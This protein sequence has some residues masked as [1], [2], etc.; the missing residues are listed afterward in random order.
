MSN[1]S[2]AFPSLLLE[3]A[4]ARIHAYKEACDYTVTDF[5]PVVWGCSD[6]VAHTL[7][8]HPHLLKDL[9]ES[10]DLMSAYEQGTYHERL[11]AAIKGVTT[12]EAL[13]KVLREFRRREMVR[14]IWRD[15][16]GWGSLSETVGDL[17]EMADACIK[18][19]AS[20]LYRW[21][22]EEVGKPQDYQ[23]EQQDL[24][25][26]AVGKLG[27]QELNL[28][29]DI[30]LIFA[31]P[32]SGETDHAS[33]PVSHEQFFTR[34]GQ[35]LIEVLNKVTEHGFVF[36][37]DMRLR[38]FGASGSLVMSFSAMENYY[39]E[40][41]RDWERYALVKARIVSGNPRAGRKLMRILRSFVYH[42]YLDYT[43]IQALREMHELIVKE[44]KSREL[45][46]N[47][48]LGAGGIR[49][50][51]FIGQAFQLIRGG[52]D[53]RLQN[54]R[55]LPILTLL[56][57]EEL[58]SRE[59]VTALREAYVFLRNVEHRLQA[60]ADQ[61]T[62]Q[63]PSDELGMVRLAFSMS[64]PDWTTFE[65]QLNHHR[66]N[67]TR[68]FQQLVAKPH[69]DDVSQETEQLQ[70]ELEAIW[71]GK[72]SAQDPAKTLH[73]MGFDDTD[74][75]LQIL[76]TLRESRKYSDGD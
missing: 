54:Q 23:G 69:I 60:V 51:E 39:Q 59:A 33:A 72:E 12:E 28:S 24:V 1:A 40:H 48:K 17:S 29:S 55:L 58:L 42:H 25:V 70:P 52:E 38:P 31:Y 36:R 41:G 21:L 30:D 53:R 9:A 47:V 13:K 14:I 2:L 62:H 44:T 68:L 4:N 8:H 37:V 16:S 66:V 56:E 43:A 11:D 74:E 3:R 57:E 64:C 75:A 10:G 34:L 5:A 73:D 32:E 7:T 27:G 18:N 61:Q 71:L 19:A 20:L 50:I 63:L 65:E 49:E 46:T 26:V 67:V 45:E 6:Y 22:C 15:L 76:T 35:Q